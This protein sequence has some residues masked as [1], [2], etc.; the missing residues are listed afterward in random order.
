MNEK[1][2]SSN[3][4]MKMA[5]VVWDEEANRERAAARPEPVVGFRKTKSGDSL[6]GV[7][8]VS[9]FNLSPNF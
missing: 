9:P 2:N 6:K 7:K 4:R 1:Y 8:V 3:R 5:S